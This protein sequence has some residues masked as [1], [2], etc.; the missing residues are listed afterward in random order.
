MAEYH[1]FWFTETQFFM[2][3]A[4]EIR[5][6]FVFSYFSAA[7]SEIPTFLHFDPQMR[8]RPLT[9]P[10][11]PHPRHTSTSALVLFLVLL[12]SGLARGPRL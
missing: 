5:L 2:V 3:E 4:S 7:K 12:R 9:P 1:L 8:T 11:A 10:T 6:F